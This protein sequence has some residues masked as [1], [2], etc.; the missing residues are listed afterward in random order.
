MDKHGVLVRMKYGG[1]RTGRGGRYQAS[2]KRGGRSGSARSTA[3]RRPVAATRR[4]VVRV[5]GGGATPAAGAM[6][7]PMQHAA[8]ALQLPS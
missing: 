6:A 2:G 7:A 8:Q 3:A 5:G 4:A 1:P